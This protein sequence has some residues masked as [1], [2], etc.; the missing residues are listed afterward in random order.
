MSKEESHLAHLITQRKCRKPVEVSSYFMGYEP[1]SVR[2]KAY[3][4]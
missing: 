1:L 3:I 4:S 2:Y